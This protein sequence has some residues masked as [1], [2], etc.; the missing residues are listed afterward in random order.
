VDVVVATAFFV[1]YL[2]EFLMTTS[3]LLT[4]A[5]GRLGQLVAR[6]LNA[7]NVVWRAYARRPEAAEKLGA[8]QVVSGDFSNQQQL[9]RAT[10]GIKTVILIA[11]DDPQ[12]D[13][14]EINVLRAAKANGVQHIVKLSAQSAGLSPPISFGKKHILVEQAI[15][16]SGLDWT[17]LRPVFFQQSFLLFADTIRKGNKII[18]PGGQGAAAFV[19][20]ND[21]ADCLVVA[22]TQPQFANKIY[23]LTGSRAI[24]FAQAGEIIGQARGK[25]VSYISPPA[26][27]AKIVLPKASGMPRWLALEVIDLLQGIS[28]NAQ[29]Q[30]SGDLQTLLGR[31]PTSF[32]SFA[33]ENAVLFKGV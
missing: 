4:G 14:H 24:T 17:F 31:G 27:L 13:V 15:Q 7:Q 12:Q 30:T 11:G 6:R 18:M 33:Q 32:E 1:N 28:R 2:R 8:D 23:T 19:S 10:E 22:A 25:S 16:A 9:I 5:T 21:V 29:A 3:M 26:W 20:A